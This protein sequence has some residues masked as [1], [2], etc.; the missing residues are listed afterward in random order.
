MA[1]RRF[2]LIL[3]S[4]RGTPNDEAPRKYQPKSDKPGRGG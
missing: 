1:G 2:R 4:R 3:S